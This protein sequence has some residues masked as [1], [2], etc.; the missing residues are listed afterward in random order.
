MAL[1]PTPANFRAE[2]AR[3]RLTRDD[4]CPLIGMNR[5]TFNMYLNEYRPLQRWAAHNIGVGINRATGRKLI[6]VDESIGL[7]SARFGRKPHT[8]VP[9]APKPR[10]KRH[11]RRP[12]EE[13]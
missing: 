3:Q 6:D 8:Q 9:A 2:M 10:Q 11:R 13:Q 7:L 5:N 1:Q 4:V 12:I